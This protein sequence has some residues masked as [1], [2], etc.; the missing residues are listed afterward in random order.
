MVQQDIKHFSYN[1]FA[2]IQQKTKVGF[3]FLA[4]YYSLLCLIREKNHS[5]DQYVRGWSKRIGFMIDLVTP[6]CIWSPRDIEIITTSFSY[7]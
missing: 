4:L 2:Q 7:I 1:K 3:F 5:G 6:D